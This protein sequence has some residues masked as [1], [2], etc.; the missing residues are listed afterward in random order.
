MQACVSRISGQHTA[1][2]DN[3]SNG[4]SAYLFRNA[5]LILEVF[6]LQEPA[7]QTNRLTPHPGPLPVEGRERTRCPFILDVVSIDIATP[8][9][10][11][12]LVRSVRLRLLVAKVCDLH[13]LHA[14]CLLVIFGGEE[15]I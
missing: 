10:V 8:N 15:A 9:G 4:R 11:L 13:L 1:W 14:F 5:R 7:H 12:D 2:T 6:A 3:A